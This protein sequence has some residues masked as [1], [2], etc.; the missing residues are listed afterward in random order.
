MFPEKVRSLQNFKALRLNVWKCCISTCSKRGSRGFY[1]FPKDN[2]RKQKWLNACGLITVRSSEKLCGDH[3]DVNAF[4]TSN[5]DR[6]PQGKNIRQCLKKD[7]VPT[8]LLPMVW[9][10][11]KGGFYISSQLLIISINM[12]LSCLIS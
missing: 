1:G 6:N 9:I 2:P 12:S 11:K 5:S 8:L 3:F 7:A 4:A 10:K